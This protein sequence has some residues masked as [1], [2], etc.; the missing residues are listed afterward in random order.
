MIM[1]LFQLSIVRKSPVIVKSLIS[2]FSTMLLEAQNLRVKQV[3]PREKTVAIT[4]KGLDQVSTREEVLKAVAGKVGPDEVTRVGPL[5]P[6]RQNMQAATITLAKGKADIL[7]KSGHVKV[8]LSC[9][10][11]EKRVEVKRYPRMG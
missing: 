4:L 11:V 6:Y 2:H 1:L 10:E 5:R 8:G 9:C 3:G 7:I